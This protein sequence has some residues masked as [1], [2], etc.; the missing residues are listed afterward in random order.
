MPSGNTHAAISSIAGG[1]LWLAHPAGRFSPEALALLGGCLAGT[2]ITPDLD[3]DEPSHSHYAVGRRLGCAGFAVW[4]L[5]WLPYG[6][7]IAHRSWVSHAPVV[8]TL[9]RVAYLGL[10]AWI[11]L[12]VMRLAGVAVAVSHLPAWW[13]W[14]L[15]G[16][17]LSDI[18][19]WAADILSTGVKK[20][21]HRR[22]KRPK[23]ADNDGDK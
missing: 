11:G 9:I 8:S 18:L 3:V 23:R 21:L 19:H 1:L 14:A 13:P 6:K 5:I 12:S 22:R 10:I 4:R 15:G 2:I 20:S 16:L 17:M 7:L